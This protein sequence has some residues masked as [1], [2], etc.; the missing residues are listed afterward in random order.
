MMRRA[1]LLVV[2]LSALLAGCGSTVEGGFE[3]ATAQT[4]FERDLAP[5]LA[6][7][8]GCHTGDDPK[9]GLDL[10]DVQAII[11]VE[12]TQLKM[13]IIEPGNHLQ[14]YLWHKVAGTQSIAG[15]L[16]QRMPVDHE[17]PAEDVDLLARWIDLGAPH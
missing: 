8:F 3:P 5:K 15:G 10:S 9:A 13:A 12:S 1:T 4:P 16:G 14:S 11:G 6:A 17:W 2:L 7:C